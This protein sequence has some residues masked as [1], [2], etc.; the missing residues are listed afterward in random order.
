MRN[1]RLTLAGV[2]VSGSLIAGTICVILLIGPVIAFDAWPARGIGAGEGRA[3]VVSDVPPSARALLGTGGF[4]PVSA[5]AAR[6][7]AAPV[8]RSAP[9]SPTARPRVRA[10]SH[11]RRRRAT[12]RAARS[13]S[14]GGAPTPKSSQP[15]TGG[16]AKAPE[17][18]NPPPAGS[19]ATESAS[20]TSR[21]GSVGGSTGGASA[22]SDTGGSSAA[23]SDNPATKG[24]GRDR[25]DGNRT[26]TPTSSS[27]A[28]ATAPADTAGGTDSV[29]PSTPVSLASGKGSGK[30]TPPGQAKKAGR[31]SDGGD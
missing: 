21:A 26:A 16:G 27:T 19:P 24:K 2:A 22:T 29:G 14:V 23:V 13:T 3:L 1:V 31:K 8:T 30:K 4:A 9:V 6:T 28:T 12:R 17:S 5:P 18:S 20:T 15:S 10:G 7:S 11:A 25:G